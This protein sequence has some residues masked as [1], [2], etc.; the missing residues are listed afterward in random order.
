[1]NGESVESQIGIITL[2]ED[3]PAIFRL[4][5]SYMYSGR[6][7]EGMPLVLDHVFIQRYDQDSKQ[8]QLRQSNDVVIFERET[9]VNLLFK[10]VFDLYIFA[11][12][13][14]ATQIQD[15]V[16]SLLFAKISDELQFPIDLLGYLDSRLPDG[17][18]LLNMITNILTACAPLQSITINEEHIPR[19][20]LSG[21]FYCAMMGH[22]LDKDQGK[23]SDESEFCMSGC[24]WHDSSAETHPKSAKLPAKS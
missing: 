22:D 20:I 1:M 10:I 5:H 23:D 12:M 7:Y 4:V 11:D 13:R 8:L 3:D 14:L 15:V 17:C 24:L 6:L 21:M 18:V 2:D 9:V 19:L 16:I